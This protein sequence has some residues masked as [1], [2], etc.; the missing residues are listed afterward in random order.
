VSAVVLQGITWLLDADPL[1]VADLWERLYTGSA[2]VDK[3]AD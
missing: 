3:E 1:D 2:Q